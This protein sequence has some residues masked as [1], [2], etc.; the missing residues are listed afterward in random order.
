MPAAAPAAAATAPV[1]A[2][3]PGA[4]PAAGGS[5]MLG[6][7]LEMMPVGTMKESGSSIGST[8]LSADTAFALAIAP[9]A[10]FDVGRNF[11][12]GASPQVIF[13]VKASNNSGPS[14]TEF[15]L[16]ARLTGRAPMSRNVELY[17]RFSPGYSI[18]SLPDG[19]SSGN[20]SLSSPKGLALDFAV[21]VNTALLPNLWLVIDLGYQ[22]SF[23]SSTLSIGTAS[24]DVDFKTNYL[25]L[26]VGLGVRL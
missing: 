24:S 19:S 6:V 17:G 26:G 3:A 14:A 8:A 23:Q 2:Q 4:E 1:I 13:H 25:H 9:F 21:G 12:I 15:D 5:S 20:S 11:S 7:M 22:I 18:V 16:R 10:D